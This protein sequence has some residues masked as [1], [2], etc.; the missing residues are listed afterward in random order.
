MGEQ[1]GKSQYD[2]MERNISQV[3]LS[4]GGRG[5]TD[6]ARAREELPTEPQRE[7]SHRWSQGGKGA[8]NGARA[9]EEPLTE[10][11]PPTEPQGE[12]SHQ[13]STSPGS[14]AGW[15]FPTLPTPLQAVLLKTSWSGS[16]G[17]EPMPSG[18]PGQ[19]HSS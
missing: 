14:T 8:A 9:G 11:G 17:T 4:H 16:S 12:R 13:R 7:R 5:A 3:T 10:P 6:G 2:Y 18:V 1:G 19:L 15:R